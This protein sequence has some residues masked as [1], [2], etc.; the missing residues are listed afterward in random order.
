M[1]SIVIA[2]LDRRIKNTAISFRRQTRCKLPDSIIAATAI[3]FESTLM[4]KDKG[5]L[6]VVFLGFIACAV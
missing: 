5:W 6:K 2:P 4:T 1:Q 3:V